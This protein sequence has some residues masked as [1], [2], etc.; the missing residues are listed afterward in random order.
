MAVVFYKD[1]NGN[2]V[3]I[4]VSGVSASQ[5]QEAVN[6]YLQENPITETKE[7]YTV[8][9]FANGDGLSISDDSIEEMYEAYRNG[10]PVILY[11]IEPDGNGGYLNPKCYYLSTMIGNSLQFINN[12]NGN[13]I[14]VLSVLLISGNTINYKITKMSLVSDENLAEAMGK[15]ADTYTTLSGYGITDA[16]TKDEIGYIRDLDIGDN[17]VDAINSVNSEIGDIDSA[18]DELHNYAQALIGGASE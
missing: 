1:A 8:T 5:V 13:H 4:P 10:M 14:I 18:L 3:E 7:V 9:A 16:Y 15:K 11:L 17:L 12:F 2:F 6:T